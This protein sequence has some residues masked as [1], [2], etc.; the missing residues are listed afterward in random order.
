MILKSSS[1][2]LTSARDNLV[3]NL[4]ACDRVFI[5]RPGYEAGQLLSFL[6]NLEE[7][8]HILKANVAWAVTFVVLSSNFRS[9]HGSEK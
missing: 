9:E 7:R 8:R 5:Q 4:T 6:A 3:T 2:F 1:K